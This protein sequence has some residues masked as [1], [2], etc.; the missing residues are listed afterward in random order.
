MGIFGFLKGLA[1][2]GA[3]IVVSTFSFGLAGPIGWG[4]VGLGLGQISG[5]IAP[6][7]L[8]NPSFQANTVSTDNMIPVAMGSAIV[9]GSR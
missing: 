8:R 9:G 4:L 1:L 2:I 7:A 6:N 5:A 3:G